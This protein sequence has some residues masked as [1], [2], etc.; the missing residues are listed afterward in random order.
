MFQK[1]GNVPSPARRGRTGLSTAILAEMADVEM[2]GAIRIGAADISLREPDASG[3]DTVD[4]F[5]KR[6]SSTLYYPT[7]EAGYAV[8]VWADGDSVIV[9]KIASTV[10]R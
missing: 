8:Q 10:K 2:N 5:A 7:R 6:L 3:A 9:K 4:R 1:L